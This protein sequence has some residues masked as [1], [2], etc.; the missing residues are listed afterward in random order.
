[1]RSH[2]VVAVDF[3]QRDLAEFA[4]VDELVARFDQV[5]RA[6][7]LR[8]DLHHAVVFARGGEHR[9]AFDNIDADRLLHVDIDARFRRL[10]HR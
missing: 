1:M 3:D 10:D 9:L 2:V 4:F 5:R 7:A 8:A 6:A